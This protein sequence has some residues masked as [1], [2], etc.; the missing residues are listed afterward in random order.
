MNNK[1]LV[2]NIL[3]SLLQQVVTII[4]GFILPKTI[5]YTY[6]SNTNGLINSINQFLTY[7]VIVE[8]GVGT[9]V[10]SL[11]YKPIANKNKN[12]V[13]KILKSA[14]KFFRTIALIYFIYIIVLCIIYPKI[15]SNNFDMNFT[16]VLIVTIAISSFVEYFTG[17]I[18]TLYLQANQEKYIISIIQ[19]VTI[20]FNTIVTILLI[21][22]GYS[23]LI[24]EMVSSCIFIIRPI[25]QKIYVE[26]KYKIKVS[27]C[28]EKYIIKQKRDAFTHQLAYAIHNNIDVFLIT[29]F[30][31]TLE[32]SV[33]MV[34]K[35]VVDGI[36]K[37]VRTIM[38]GVSDFFG[39]MFAEEKYE[40]INKKFT[41]YEF[42]YFTIITILYNLCLVL[43]V[44][45]VSI[46]T[47]GI[48]DT[49]YYQ[50]LFA[51]VLTLSEFIWAIR[52]PANELINAVGHFKQT[53]NM[54]LIEVGVNLIISIALVNKL[55]L[56]G[57]AIGTL[58]AMLIRGIYMIYYFSRNVLKRS[59]KI[60]LKF[61]G[62]IVVETIILTVIGLI[63]N[64]K[65]ALTNYIEW[66]LF[67]VIYGI[68][69]TIFII[70]VNMILN[71]KLSK[72]I[73]NYIKE[74]IR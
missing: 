35:L 14:Q 55:G 34:Y 71:K 11:L 68:I 5:I 25:V 67:A 61:I 46:Y 57:V 31:G 44:P 38:S 13:E 19:I 58:V 40:E 48:A 65:I 69:I 59:I 1:K 51:I 47:K 53:K 15:V 36:K 73:Y 23:I 8:A 63:C 64:E 9:V 27:K 20:I 7:I 74:R 43:I 42:I 41:M 17:M 66:I 16:K 62:I 30:M 12:D 2:K 4:C 56:L 33:Y 70:S 72:E 6:G 3:I 24:I 28:V 54:A 26:K 10:K 18:Y 37:I 21:K 50:P 45:F 22:R 52:Y 29:L 49:N 32:V 60:D 39:N